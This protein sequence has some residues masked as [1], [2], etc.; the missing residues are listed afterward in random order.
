MK[1]SEILPLLVLVAG[2]NSRAIGDASSGEVG[3]EEGDGGTGDDAGDGGEDAGGRMDL[4][5]SDL[6]PG[7]ECGDNDACSPED[8]CLEFECVPAIEQRYVLEI[9]DV[10]SSG[11]QNRVHEYEFTHHSVPTVVT[12]G[13][14]PAGGPLLLFEYELP[15]PH[16]NWAE[17]GPGEGVNVAI[18]RKDDNKD[19][20]YTVFDVTLERGAY[21]GV[22]VD[23]LH[24]GVWTLPEIEDGRGT[25]TFSFT[26]YASDP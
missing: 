5:T 6:P 24:E 25:I 12:R 21:R 11:G 15:S 7:A 14:I 17:A 2:C 8:V 23:R 3:E 18:H 26:P 1:W 4:G 16:P 19:D 10:Q 22:P 20:E 9:V 13:H